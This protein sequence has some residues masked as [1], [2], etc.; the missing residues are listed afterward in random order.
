MRGERA[1]SE[2]LTP[3]QQ[4]VLSF[5]RDH[6]ERTGF[7]PT[8]RQIG[9]HL[10]VSSPNSVMEHLRALERKGAITRKPRGHQTQI[11]FHANDASPNFYFAAVL[12]LDRQ[13]PNRVGTPKQMDEFRSLL[14]QAEKLF[15]S[16]RQ[17][18]GAAGEHQP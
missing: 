18:P 8:I 9:A 16:F 12:H 13:Y 6:V 4:A 11:E 2:P 1:Y 14:R 3:R 10:G 7:V 5:L 17:Q 15:E